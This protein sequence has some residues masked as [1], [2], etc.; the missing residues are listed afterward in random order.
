MPRQTAKPRATRKGKAAPASSTSAGEDSNLPN[1]INNKPHDDAI[2]ANT[3]EFAARLTTAYRA[4]ERSRPP[5]RDDPQ[6]LHKLLGPTA[7]LLDDAYTEELEEQVQ[8]ESATLRRALKAL[9]SSGKHKNEIPQ[10]TL[11]LWKACIRLYR[12]T[13]F[14]LVSPARCMFASVSIKQVDVASG[15]TTEM[16][17][18]VFWTTPFCEQLHTLCAHSM[19]QGFSG[20]EGWRAISILLQF[21]V[22][23]RTNDSRPWHFSWPG[24]S[25]IMANFSKVAA[26][27]SSRSMIQRLESQCEAWLHAGGAIL[28]PESDAFVLVAQAVK[29]TKDSPSTHDGRPAF[30][31]ETRDVSAIIDALDGLSDAVGPVF[32]GALVRR[33]IFEAANVTSLPD[34]KRL[35]VW[36][37]RSWVTQ[38]RLSKVAA[39][40]P[41][42]PPSVHAPLP[43][44][45]HLT[46]PVHAPSRPPVPGDS[47]PEDSDPDENFGRIGG[48]SDRGDESPDPEKPAGSSPNQALLSPGATQLPDNAPSGAQVDNKRS[49]G[50]SEVL[51]MAE[52]AAGHEDRPAT[53]DTRKTSLPLAWRD[54]RPAVALVHKRDGTSVANAHVMFADAQF[55]RP[56]WL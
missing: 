26:T 8:N 31:V 45:V 47:N 16:V 13:P 40:T 30:H 18:G 20:H 25:Y 33:R 50:A 10:R 34:E 3:A 44:P 14:D 9:D 4:I 48:F 51:P 38:L 52:A 49:P 35:R 41:V 7:A 1:P 36:M 54:Q 56:P 15:S 53:P 32:Q 43:S 55:E 29:P 23:C 46:S 24:D 42:P 17:D 28:S 12:R 37:V 2:T 27:Q 11:D 22:I 19:F 5:V 21:A 39:Q 6:T